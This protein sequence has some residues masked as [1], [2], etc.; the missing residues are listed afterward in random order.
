MMRRI[1]TLPWVFLISGNI[2]IL[3][4][5]GYITFLWFAADHNDTWTKIAIAGWTTTS[6]A[7][8]SVVLR[9]AI[10][11]QA[12]I[13][14]SMI[15]GIVLESYGISLPKLAVV[16]IMRSASPAPHT[17]FRHIVSGTNMKNVLATVLAAIL[18]V[19]TIFLQFTSTALL[20]DVST[21]L[22]TG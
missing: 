18:T 3:A 20:A 16:S 22:V 17:L 11:A 5:T 13:A 15:A 12:G 1:G 10:T 7:I 21:G 2:G 4:F 9:S 8:A 14:C 6:I 19:T